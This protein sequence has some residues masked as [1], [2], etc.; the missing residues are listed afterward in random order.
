MNLF[1]APQSFTEGSQAKNKSLVVWSQDQVSSVE[2]GELRESRGKSSSGE[3]LR[4]VHPGC[5]PACPSA[6]S[7]RGRTKGNTAV[8]RGQ[9]WPAGLEGPFPALERNCQFEPLV[10]AF[11]EAE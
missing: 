3:A 2:M 11:A 5:R 1:Q 4:T 6:G 9:P 10:S 7:Q 8:R